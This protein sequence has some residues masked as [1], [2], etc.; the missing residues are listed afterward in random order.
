MITYADGVS[1]ADLVLHPVRLRILQAFLGGRH[2]TTGDLARELPDVA[3]A[4]LYRHVSRLAEGGVLEVVSERQVRGAVER[5]YALRQENAWVDAGS[6][7]ALGRQGQS[8]AFATFAAALMAAYDR[9]LDAGATDPV[10]DGVSYS[11]NALWL[12]DEEHLDF[13]LDVARIVAPRAAN[14]PA[15]GRRRRLAASAFFPV[16]DFPVTGDNPATGENDE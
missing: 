11:M 6:F 15:A 3:Q 7:A 4:G 10:R 1:T 14:G 5:T 16:P 9:Y 12:T 8:V 13:L 2:L